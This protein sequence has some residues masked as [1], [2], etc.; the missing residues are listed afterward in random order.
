V[1]A[2]TREAGGRL[3]NHGQHIGFIKTVDV[4]PGE[5]QESFRVAASEAVPRLTAGEAQRCAR[6][7]LE[8]AAWCAV[9][10]DRR[11]PSASRD[12]PSRV[13]RWSNCDPG[14]DAST[15]MRLDTVGAPWLTMMRE[16][17][18]STMT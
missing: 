8:G 2:A 1:R 6:E 12:R 5:S 7:D 11:R 9:G 4:T 16:T 14:V 18:E 13:H 15:V 10:V 17:A 3:G